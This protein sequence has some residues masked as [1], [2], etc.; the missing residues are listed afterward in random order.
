MAAEQR[1]DARGAALREVERRLKV[2]EGA[3]VAEK[4]RSAAARGETDLTAEL[5]TMRDELRKAQEALAEARE[6]CVQCR[7]QIEHA[8]GRSN[9]PELP[10]EAAEPEAAEPEAAEPEAAEPAAAEP[11]AAELDAAEPDAAELLDVSEPTGAPAVAGVPLQTARLPNARGMGERRADWKRPLGAMT[12]AELR[13]TIGEGPAAQ[14]GKGVG[15]DLK[16]SIYGGSSSTE[17]CGGQ[18]RWP[19]PP[20]KMARK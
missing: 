18:Q 9:A 19:L 14:F 11:D 17:L 13:S 1:L 7:W 15:R 12:E 4:A 3:K 20:S 8:M 5:T 6:E 2:A 10:D 16:G